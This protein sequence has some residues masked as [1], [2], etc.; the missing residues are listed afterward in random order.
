[1]MSLREIYSVIIVHGP[2]LSA[3]IDVQILS[4]YQDGIVLLG[5]AA[6]PLSEDVLRQMRDYRRLGVP[7]LGFVA[8]AG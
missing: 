2:P 7:L 3:G 8:L 1:M 6:S 4:A 5:D